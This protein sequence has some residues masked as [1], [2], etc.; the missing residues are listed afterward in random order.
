[1]TPG[2]R[3][4]QE[5]LKLLDLKEEKPDPLDI[6][7]IDGGY[8]ATDSYQ[9]FP[10]VTSDADGCFKTKFFLH[11][12][13]YTNDGA[14]K[15]LAQLKDGE[16]LYVTV[17]LTNPKTTT[18]VQI[19]SE[20]YYMLGWSPNYLVHDLVNAMANSPDKLHAKVI[21]INPAPAPSKQRILIELSG[22][23]PKNY[24]PMDGLEFT[25]LIS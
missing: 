5:Y 25:P 17:E 11:G 3:D 15:R 2:R 12:W 19:Q 16:P 1:M 6:M 21:K 4:F 23:W 8:R 7:A 22:Q 14:K 18:A 13:R 10:K 24:K 20:D 9:V